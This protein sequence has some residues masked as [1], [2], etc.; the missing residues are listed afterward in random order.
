[1]K[2]INEVYQR[3]IIRKI[4]NQCIMVFGK[5]P[6]KSRVFPEERESD[7]ISKEIFT[8][9]FLNYIINK[10]VISKKPI[11]LECKHFFFNFKHILFKF[12]TLIFCS[13]HSFVY[14]PLHINFILSIKIRTSSHRFVTK[15]K[16]QYL[17]NT[18]NNIKN[19]KFKTLQNLQHHRGKN[20]LR[21]FLQ[22]LYINVEIFFSPKI[23]FRIK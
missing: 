12:S 19:S 14:R 15:V 13:T 10:N 16:I 5:N 23:C 8:I 21:H 17:R 11:I 18:L 20:S 2:Y 22:S 1:M 3:K 9:L 7:Q 4:T 6:R